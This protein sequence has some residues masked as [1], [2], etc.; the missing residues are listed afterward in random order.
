MGRP[1]DK[2]NFGDNAASGNQLT[3]WVNLDGTRRKAVIVSQKGT[4]DYDVIDAASNTGRVTLVDKPVNV[5]SVSDRIGLN[6]AAILGKKSD[7]SLIRVR[8][9]NANDAKGF[10]GVTYSWEY[11]DDNVTNPPGGGILYIRA[12]ETFD[13]AI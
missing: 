2:E 12:D 8:Q 9:L 6:E 10:D 11:I 13:D 7:G 3:I 5:G 1:L 4:N